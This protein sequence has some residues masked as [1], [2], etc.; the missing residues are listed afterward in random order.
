[1]TAQHLVRSDSRDESCAHRRA[2]VALL[3]AAP[4]PAVVLGIDGTVLY[5]NSAV[6]GL[7]GLPAAEMP[8]AALASLF[9]SSR[10][11]EQLISSLETGESRC[12]QELTLRHRDGR[13]F[14]ASASAVR[15]AGDGAEGVVVYLRDLSERCRIEA[16]LQSKNDEL[17]HCVQALAHDLRSPLVA[18]LGFSRLLR[19]DYGSLL[20]ETGLHFVDRIEQAG[21][22]ME[23]LI[24]DLLE[25]SRISQP[26]EQRQMIDPRTV[27]TQIQAELKPRLDAGNIQLELPSNPPPIYCDRTRLYQLFANLVGN[28]IDHM[29]P[30]QAP[31]ISVSVTEFPQRHRLSVRDLG[32]GIDPEHHNRIFEVFQSIGPRADGRRGTGIGL[33]IV[34]RIA[35]T[36]GGRAW[37][38]SQPGEGATFH[39]EIPRQDAPTV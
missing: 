34:R 10:E 9:G 15:L 26:G 16:E 7:F 30:C 19:Q 13:I 38:E 18:L 25:L 1:M 20:D 22:T 24:H 12:N 32:R 5:A 36:H 3:D 4:D 11:V 17:E 2:F 28:A 37:V 6:E 8:G 14:R 21:R 27:L 35:E 29:G 39:V 33:A 23:D 31:R